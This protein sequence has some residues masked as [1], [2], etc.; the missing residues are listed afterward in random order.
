MRTFLSVILALACSL[1]GMA[2]Q[3]EGDSRSS[4]ELI[5][6]AVALMDNGAVGTAISVLNGVLEKDSTNMVARYELGYAHYINDN[7][8]RAIEEFSKIVGKW[9]YN[10]QVYGMLGNSYDMNGQPEKAGEVYKKGLEKFPRSAM[11]LNEL[12]VLALK[13][14]D[15]NKSLD[16]CLQGIKANP[17]YS[18]CYFRAA[19]LFLQSDYPAWGMVY[20]EMYMAMERQNG[21]RIKEM[22]RLMMD[23]CKRCIKI[24]SDSAK[25]GFANDTIYLSENFTPDEVSAALRRFDLAGYELG[26]A[27]AVNAAKITVVDGESMCRVRK[28]FVDK[29]VADSVFTEK[30]NPY[31]KHLL[32]VRASGYEDAYNHFVTMGYDAPALSKWANSHPFEW[33]RF[34]DWLNAYIP[35]MGDGEY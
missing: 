16:Y 33:N 29:I 1:A 5:E 26:M 21:E 11:L 19:S 30:P 25:V 23:A 28:A 20:G 22:S 27:E 31:V 35:D 34:A 17:Q 8:P 10:E 7:M 3:I 32:A 13:D 6:R 2:R 4:D 18:P 9:N 15:Y 12:S 14:E 24:E